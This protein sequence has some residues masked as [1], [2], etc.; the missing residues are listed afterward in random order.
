LAKISERSEQKANCFLS[1]FNF[2]LGILYT[3]LGIRGCMNQ[4]NKGTNTLIINKLREYEPFL[5]LGITA[6]K[7]AYK[8]DKKQ[9]PS[10]NKNKIISMTS[11]PPLGSPSAT[12]KVQ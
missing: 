9:V 10:S 5:N 1:L 2:L 8:I 3:N 11:P 7:P 12:E 6:I 4:N